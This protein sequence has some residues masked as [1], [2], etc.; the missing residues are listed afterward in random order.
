MQ[1]NVEKHE[2]A[3]LPKAYEPQAVESKWYRFWEEGGYFKPRPNPARPP[4]VISMPPPNVTGALHLGHAITATVEDILIRYHRMA[5]VETLWVPGEDHAGIATQVVVERLLTQEGTDRHTLGREAFLERVWQWVGQY[6]SRIQDQHRRLGAS[7][8][9]SRER[10]TLDEGLSRAVREVFV[11]LYDEGLIYRGE[12]IINWCP[13]DLSALSDLEV[14]RED[15]QGTLTYVRYPLKPEADSQEPTEYISVATT[16]PETIL[17]DTAV[18]VNP[19]DARYTNLV[20]RVAL[21]PVIGREIPIVADE[22]VEANFGTGA[23]KVTPAHDP[24]DFEIGI[25]HNLPRIQVIGFDA[26]MTAEAG[27]YAGQDRY[28]ARKNIVAELQR[29]GLIVKIEDYMVPLG[30]CQRCNTVVEPLISKQWFVKMMPLATPA[31]GAVKHEQVKIVPERFNKVYTDWLENIHDWC[32]SRQLWWGH[33]IPVWYCDN[34]GEM[35]VSRT[36]VTTCPHCESGAIHQDEDV[37]DTWFSS[38]LWPF[39]TLGWPDITPDLRRYYP[40]SVMETGYDIIFFWVARMVMGGIH[41]LGTP[42]FHTIY[43][44]GLVRDAKGEKMSKSKNNVIDPL[45]VMEQYGTDALRF[46]LATSSTPGNDMKLVPERIVGNRNFANKIWNA[47]RF[48]LMTTAEISGGVPPLSVLEP[49]TLADRWL[50]SRLARLTDEVTH[51]LDDYQLGEAGRRINEFFWSDYCD[52]YVEISKVQMQGDAATRL[53]TAG[54]LRAV[55]DQSLRL[56]HPFMPFVTEEVWQHLYHSAVPDE[57]R[58]PAAALII[59]PWP[60]SQARWI[61]EAAEQEFGL[62]QEVIV[63]I[64]D[65]RNQMEVESAR[66]IPVMLAAGSQAPMFEQQAPLI[67]FLARTEKPQLHRNLAQ[68]PE[69]AMSLLAGPVE[70]YLPLAGMIDVAKE[71]SRLDKEVGLAQQEIARVQAKLANEA[72]V[73]KARPEVVA[74]EREKLVAQEERIAKLLAR[75]AELAG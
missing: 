64:R 17:G 1:Q 51:L 11:R 36:D 61:N 34:C 44:H 26:Q 22:A 56:L 18:A 30:H 65:A 42:P 23:V 52:W 43:L 40:T 20:G 15:T 75:R 55:L 67:E 68:K 46:T 37:L 47:S 73:A 28:E 14:E 13:H 71:L 57:A 33:R 16:R 9:W 41:F 21:L 24:V 53:T 62:L 8:D 19:R 63:R 38:W 54:I 69:Q 72:F 29:L 39:S 31:L 25:R 48:V 10:F 5:G 27:P 70:I 2:A 59:A 12:R 74:K 50:L 66:R 49:R 58:W 35:T 4:F 6:K 32:I 3:P 45:D 60:T 7:C